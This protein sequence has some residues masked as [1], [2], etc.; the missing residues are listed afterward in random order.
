MTSTDCQDDNVLEV[1]MTMFYLYYFEYY[2][3]IN[4]VT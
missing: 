3:Y 2:N 1:K 4:I